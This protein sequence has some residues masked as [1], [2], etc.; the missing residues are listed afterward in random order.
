[1]SFDVREFFLLVFFPL[2]FSQTLVLARL[3]P[4]VRWHLQ[5][6][7]VHTWL[8]RARFRD[9][10][11]RHELWS[12]LFLAPPVALYSSHPF[13]LSPLPFILSLPPELLQRLPRPSP[14]PLLFLS[15][16]PYPQRCFSLVNLTIHQALH[17]DPQ[18]QILGHHR[19]IVNSKTGIVVLSLDIGMVIQHAAMDCEAHF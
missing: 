15:P 18:L 14:R 8:L 2:G 12:I 1:M 10:P 9:F 13:L 17:R 16:L 6:P 4:D 3:I 19:L 5:F 11:S 7:E